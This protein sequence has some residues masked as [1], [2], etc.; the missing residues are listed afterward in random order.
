M[1]HLCVNTVH[2]LGITADS[3]VAQNGGLRHLLA[4]S[5]DHTANRRVC[6]MC[7]RGKGWMGIG[8]GGGGGLVRN[9]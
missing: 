1:K 6:W 7:V 4:H 8:G 9:R 3:I 2:L 5:S